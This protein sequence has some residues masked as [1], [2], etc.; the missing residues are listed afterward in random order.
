MHIIPRPRRRRMALHQRL[1]TPPRKPLPVAVQKHRIRLPP[2][3]RFLR[4]QRPPLVHIPRQSLRRR[5]PEQRM[6]L[7]IP[8]PPH[9]HRP[10]PKVNVPHIHTLN[11]R[12][13]DPAPVQRLQQRLIP[14]PQRRRII[15]RLQKPHRFPM[16]Q[17]PRQRLRHLQPETSPR[18]NRRR[19]KHPLL[20]QKQI[21]RPQHRQLARHANPFIPLSPV[22]RRRRQ[23]GQ[24]PPQRKPVHIP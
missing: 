7:L 9:Q 14:H 21:K 22:P 18:W 1:D 16:P 23:P 15:R 10:L 4:Q 24:I 2:R 6:T 5:L 12:Q 13:P 8:L 17:K 11:F 20:H 19:L 3:P